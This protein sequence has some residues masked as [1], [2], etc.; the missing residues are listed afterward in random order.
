[1]PLY[2]EELIEEVRSRSDIAAVIGARI[3]LTRKGA[4]LW[5]CCP[6]HNEKTPSFSV[7][8][9]KQMYYCFGCGA[10]GNVIT[11]LMNYDNISFQDAMTELA[12]RAGITLPE[13][14]M[15]EDE[16]K[17][18]RTRQRYFALNGEAAKYFYYLLRDPAGK[19]GMD[20]FRRRGLSEETMRRF[21]LGFASSQYDD[22]YRHLKKKG[23]QDDEMLA[24]SLIR[25]SED[26][27]ARDFFFNRVMFPI[28]DR[29]NR[30]I[31]FGG[32]VLDSSKPKYM[33]SQETPV[34]DKGRNLY[35]LNLARSSR[36]PYFLL[37]EGYMDV[38]SL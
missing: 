14:E 3:K 18:E 25:F 28:L 33:N 8:P 36:R 13:R 35:G 37:C 11:F 31:G 6:F 30:V 5:A 22:L 19:T 17:K 16:K 15:S 21:G 34:F 23:F 12:A 38:I 7:S 1:M 20:Y 2:P 27:G 24:L 4:N 26:R 29:S 9:G 32:R 10:G